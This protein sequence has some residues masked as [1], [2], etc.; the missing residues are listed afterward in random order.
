VKRNA[1]IFLA[2]FFLACTVQATPVPTPAATSSTKKLPEAFNPTRCKTGNKSYVYW[3]AGSQVFQFKYNPTE[4]I[5]PI[6]ES[7]SVGITLDAKREVPPA[8]NP[9]EPE[10]CYGNPLRAGGMPYISTYAGELFHKVTG[11]KIDI[12]TAGVRGYGAIPSGLRNTGLNRLAKLWFSES[13]ICWKRTSGMDECIPVNSVDKD[14]YKRS[15]FFKIEKRMLS[16][17]SQVEDVYFVMKGVSEFLC[18]RR[19]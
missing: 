11:R 4:P 17:H 13:K 19:C 9:K 18:V 5:Y 15:H 3:A 2:T 14:D 1:W 16:K 10:G 8:P 6:A 12:G 7:D